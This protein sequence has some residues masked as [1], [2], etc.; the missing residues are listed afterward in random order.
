MRRTP[1]VLDGVTGLAAALLADAVSPGT[2]RWWLVPDASTEPA[3]AP[4]LRRLDLTP[5]IDRALGAPA[6][7]SGLLVLPLLSAACAVN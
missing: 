1:V 3:S 7:A 4:A 5:V 6:A 2:A